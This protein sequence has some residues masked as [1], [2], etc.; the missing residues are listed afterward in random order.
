MSAAVVLTA[1]GEPRES[2]WAGP[3][4]WLDLECAAIE[5]DTKDDPDGGLVGALATQIEL[6][7]ARRD[8]SCPRRIEAQAIS[9]RLFVVS[10]LARGP[11]NIA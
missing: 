6:L 2:V 10:G 3:P 1:D 11:P 5:G 9:A 8:V 4:T 7:L